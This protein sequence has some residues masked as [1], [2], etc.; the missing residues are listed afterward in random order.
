MLRIKRAH[1]INETGHF[2]WLIL[3]PFVNLWFA[4]VLAYRRGTPG[5]N[6]FGPDPSEPPP[7]P[8]LKEMPV[9]INGINLLIVEDLC[10]LCGF[11]V[12]IRKA[13]SG[14]HAGKLFR[15]C[16]KYPKCKFVELA[17]T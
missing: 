6:Q 5:P 3:V 4:F 14:K 8:E 16:S 17:D 1:D 12:A 10:L 11:E 7:V 15:V 2:C 9:S 13:S